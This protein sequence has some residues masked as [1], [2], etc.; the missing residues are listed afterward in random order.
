MQ[1]LE[2][3]VGEAKE[4]AGKIDLMEAQL[5][6]VA[7]KVEEWSEAGKGAR[8]RRE[9]KGVGGG[10]DMR[11]RTLVIGGLKGKPIKEGTEWLRSSVMIVQVPLP[12]DAFVKDGDDA[13]IS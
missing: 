7:K 2:K 4:K 3:Q 1:G 8:V 13:I 10:G 11:S 12:S 5:Q 9:G 6:E